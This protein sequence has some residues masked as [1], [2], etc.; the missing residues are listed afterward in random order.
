MFP[1]DPLGKAT[2]YLAAL[3]RLFPTQKDASVIGLSAKLSGF[4]G[5]LTL[6]LGVLLDFQSSALRRV[7]VVAQFVGLLRKPKPGEAIDPTTQP[8]RILADGVA[9]W[10]TKTDELNLRIALRNSR[11]WSAELTGGASLFYG[12]P[13]TDGGRKGT[14]ISVGGFHPDYVPPG[15][16]IFV[17]PRLALTLSKGDHLKIQFR[18]YVAFTPSSLQFGISGQIQAKFYGFGIRGLMSLDALFGFDGN[19]SIRFEF[20]VELL[21]GSR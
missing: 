9:I 10:D 21:V 19:F 17:P 2:Q 6:D 13:E 7:Y 8:F 18:A 1:D 3:E 5:M 14:Y 20:S 11:I 12:S 4:G 16:K 15:N